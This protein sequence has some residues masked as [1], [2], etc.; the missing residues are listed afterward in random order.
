MT[1]LH[2]NQITTYYDPESSEGTSRTGQLWKVLAHHSSVEITE[3]SEPVLVKKSG[4]VDGTSNEKGKRK[5]V[6]RIN[7]N[8]SE[9]DGKF[10]EKTYCSSDTSVSMIFKNSGGTFL[11]R[12]TGCKVKSST[13]TGQKYPSHG[14]VQMSFEIWGWLVAFT[15][16]ATTTYTSVPDGFVNW[17]D[18]TVKIDAVSQIAWWGFTYSIQND[19]EYQHDNNG[20]VTAIIRGDRSLDVQVD[21]ALEDTASTQFGQAQASFAVVIIEI[22]LNADDYSFGATA[23]KEVGV[24]A[25]RTKVSGLRLVGQPATLTIT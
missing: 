15:E 5:V 23:Y 14:P 22:L 3:T 12:V 7:C 4:S 18:V 24:I 6:V 25:D 13:V 9:A 2:G 20:A 11:W 16:P 8:P 1:F 10:F 19:L 21:K 17:S